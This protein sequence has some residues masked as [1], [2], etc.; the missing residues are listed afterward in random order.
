MTTTDPAPVIRLEHAI[1]RVYAVRDELMPDQFFPHIAHR[2]HQLETHADQLR[3]ELADLV[4]PTD[5]AR[6]ARLRTH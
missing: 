4:E 2:I 3:A 1:R 5:P 6:A